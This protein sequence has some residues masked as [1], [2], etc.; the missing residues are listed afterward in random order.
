MISQEKDTIQGALVATSAD[1]LLLELGEND[2]PRLIATTAPFSWNLTS[3][4]PDL[5]ERRAA[6]RGRPAPC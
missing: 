3:A 1:I 6:G 5:A 4:G 2:R